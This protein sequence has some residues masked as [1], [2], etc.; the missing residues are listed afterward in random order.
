[1]KRTWEVN[2]LL[3]PVSEINPDALEIAHHLDIERANGTVRGSVE[4]VTDV[5]YG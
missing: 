4:A 2:H 3:H 1:M 5:C